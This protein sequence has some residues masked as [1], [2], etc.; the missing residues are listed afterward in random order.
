MTISATR[1]VAG[2]LVSQVMAGTISVRL[3]AVAGGSRA[4]AAAVFE[5]TVSHPDVLGGMEIQ[6][7]DSKGLVEHI[8][9]RDVGAWLV[10]YLSGAPVALALSVPDAAKLPTPWTARRIELLANKVQAISAA[11]IIA[12][13]TAK[14]DRVLAW[15]ES[16]YRTEQFDQAWRMRELAALVEAIQNGTPLVLT[17]Q[18]PPPAP[19]PPAPAPE[20]PPPPPATPAPAPEPPP[21]PAPEPAPGP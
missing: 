17:P 11:N 1:V 20:P 10:R 4:R 3:D 16:A 19:P 6:L 14:E 2:Y 21:A 9:F 15:E 13:A 8:G 5:V 12:A 18:P 7:V